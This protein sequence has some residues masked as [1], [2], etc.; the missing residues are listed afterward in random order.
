MFEFHV[1]YVNVSC[2]LNVLVQRHNEGHEYWCCF[3]PERLKLKT[4][5]VCV[6]VRILTVDAFFSKNWHLSKSFFIAEKERR[7]RRQARPISPGYSTDSNYGSIDI[8]HK[9]YPKSQR[10]RQLI[11]QSKIK[12]S[13]RDDGKEPVTSHTNNN[14]KAGM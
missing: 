1:Q 9:P 11:E 12:G 7:Q 6:Y 2:L 8:V 3:I 5:H 14:T 4:I 10:K 13:P